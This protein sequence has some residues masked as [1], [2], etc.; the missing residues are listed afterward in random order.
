[1]VLF[2][3]VVWMSWIHGRVLGFDDVGHQ[4]QEERSKLRNNEKGEADQKEVG[5]YTV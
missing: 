5:V 2:D 4:R 1:M 3:N